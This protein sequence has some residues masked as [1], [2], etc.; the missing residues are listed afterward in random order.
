M[1]EIQTVEKTEK[2][3]PLNINILSKMLNHRKLHKRV[4]NDV[5]HVWKTLINFQSS[6]PIFHHIGETDSRPLRK[7][8]DRFWVDP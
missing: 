1:L 3:R 7:L 5:N 2:N 8:H 4:G 6:D